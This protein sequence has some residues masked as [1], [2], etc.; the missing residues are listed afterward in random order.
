[1]LEGKRGKDDDGEKEEERNEAPV[2]PQTPLYK[3]DGLLR[4]RTRSRALDTI[5][6]VC[7]KVV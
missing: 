1:M 4:D 2:A 6:F 3:E 7:K 5:G